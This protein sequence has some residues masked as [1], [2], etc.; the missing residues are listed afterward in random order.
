MIVE[1]VGKYRDVSVRNC[2]ASVNMT[3]YIDRLISFLKDNW[4]EDRVILLNARPSKF[5]MMADGEVLEFNIGDKERYSEVMCKMILERINCHFIDVPF[6]P[7]SRDGSSVHYIHLLMNYLKDVLDLIVS[8]VPKGDVRYTNLN[9]EYRIK[10]EDL[11]AKNNCDYDNLRS[12]SQDLI[13]AGHFDEAAGVLKRLVDNGDVNSM[14]RLG[15]MYFD[16]RGLRRDLDKAID[17]L[18]K[19]YSLDST[20]SV[21][22][23]FEALERR[24]SEDDIKLLVTLLDSY[25]SQNSVYAM[26]KLGHIYGEGI[27]VDRDEQKAVELYWRAI[28]TQAPWATKSKQLAT[29]KLF[30]ILWQRKSS[31]E[32]S[33]LMNDLTDY[34]LKG[35]VEA[36]SRLAMM[37]RDGV[38][39]EAD[40]DK[41]R[42]LDVSIMEQSL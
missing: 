35:S 16:G 3:Y 36:R 1:K 14:W 23:Y 7:V 20:G 13:K 27:G 30:D 12:Y 2:D 9:L 4:G 10:V 40:V 33:Q 21:D 6:D 24:G 22:Y 11:K 17:I 26:Y 15:K 38:G 18:G 29:L 28:R 31:E 8:H 41:A 32:L 25:V 37:Y 34:S 42:E 39:I 5:R 19:A